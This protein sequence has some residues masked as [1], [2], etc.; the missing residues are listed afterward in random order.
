MSK[1]FYLVAYD[2]EV[3]RSRTRLA[4]LLKG[5]GER[6]QRSVFELFLD[7]RQ[8]ERLRKAAESLLGENDSVRWYL[9]CESCKQTVAISGVGKLTEIPDIWI[10]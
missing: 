10:V 5:F 6:V 9:L 2:I 3:D 7:E 8:F 1:R 4:K